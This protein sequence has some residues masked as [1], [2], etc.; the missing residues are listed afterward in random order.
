VELESR[1]AFGGFGAE[2]MGFLLVLLE[3]GDEL[4]VEAAWRGRYG[5]SE[6]RSKPSLLM[7]ILLSSNLPPFYFSC[8]SINYYPIQIDATFA[9]TIRKG[10]EED[11][12]A[13]SFMG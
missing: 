6:E 1:E 9:R 11:Q 2:G 10:R 3:G 13:P 12:R 5:L 8:G 7:S 4:A